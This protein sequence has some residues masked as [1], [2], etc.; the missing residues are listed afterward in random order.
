MDGSDYEKSSFKI[1]KT[2]FWKKIQNGEASNFFRQV[3]IFRKR[4]H[5]FVFLLSLLIQTNIFVFL[6]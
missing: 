2:Y 5:S 3:G 4:Y 1:F 6:V